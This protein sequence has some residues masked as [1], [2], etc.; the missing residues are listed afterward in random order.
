MI[1]NRSTRKTF[2]PRFA[3]RV[4]TYMFKPA[5]ALITT[6]SVITA[7][8]IPSSV[9]K[10]LSLCARNASSDSLRVSAADATERLNLLRRESALAAPLATRGKPLILSTGVTPKQ[11]SSSPL[12]T[13]M[14][15][16]GQLPQ[17]VASTDPPILAGSY[18][19]RLRS[20]MN[21]YLA[22]FH[23]VTSRAGS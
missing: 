22:Y 20:A 6:T 2:A 23:V 19:R 17:F 13:L 15:K 8:M 3:T 12:H 21:C 11:A 9:R 7:R 1:P 4:A 14:Y 16:D 5:I 10:L 18:R